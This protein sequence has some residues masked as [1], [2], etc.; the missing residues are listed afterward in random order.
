MV[1]AIPGHSSTLHSVRWIWLIPAPYCCFCVIVLPFP[2]NLR[3]FES[4]SAYLPFPFFLPISNTYY[5][6]HS[7]LIIK[8]FSNWYIVSLSISTQNPGL[9]P[10]N[11]SFPMIS[12][13]PQPHTSILLLCNLLAE[14]APF[15]KSPIKTA[16]SPKVTLYSPSSSAQVPLLRYFIKPEFQSWA[17]SILSTNQPLF[18]PICAHP[19]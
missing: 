11:F 14:A 7:S 13:P 12:F 6:L 1:T 9:L 19:A 10:L 15:L 2:Q 3:F 16:N 17:L 4:P 5:P 8:N 18:H